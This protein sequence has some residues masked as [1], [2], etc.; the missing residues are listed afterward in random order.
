MR[1]RESFLSFPMRFS[2]DAQEWDYEYVNGQFAG[3]I[4]EP[5]EP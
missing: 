1:L 5:M 3:P 4:P 2:E